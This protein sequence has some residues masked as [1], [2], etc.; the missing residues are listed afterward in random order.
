[1]FL[2]LC[3]C[4]CGRTFARNVPHP[5][6]SDGALGPSGL[7][8][9]LVRGHLGTLLRGPR[10]QGA[11]DFF[12]HHTST[13]HT[14]FFLSAIFWPTQVG[15]WVSALGATLPV[16][17][18]FALGGGGV[19]GLGLVG[20]VGS[21]LVWSVLSVCLFVCRSVL[22]PDA[23]IE[24]TA[25]LR[26]ESLSNASACAI[27][28]CSNSFNDVSDDYDDYSPPYD[29]DSCLPAQCRL[30][31]FLVSAFSSYKGKMLPVFA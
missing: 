15:F 31:M 18:R 25:G 23:C 12:F 13:G 4:D 28:A 11:V 8:G 2:G 6:G 19:F 10:W 16:Q 26:H 30:I 29:C 14:H 1:M 3:F 9:S 5:S 27:V 17:C 7:P 20:R 21:G 22:L 24:A